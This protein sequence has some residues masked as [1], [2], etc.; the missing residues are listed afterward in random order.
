[1][2]RFALIITAVWGLLGQPVLCPSGL[3]TACCE[4]TCPSGDDA[5]SDCEDACSDGRQDEGD[6]ER[7]ETCCDGEN[8]GS[9]C[10][11]SACGQVCNALVTKPSPFAKVPPAELSSVEVAVLA[12]NMMSG[13]RGGSFDGVPSSTRKVCLKLPYSISDRPLLL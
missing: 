2:M 10:Q 6:C 9:A 12:G 11:C 13:S 1:M 4:H 3:W 7:E 5:G 8:S